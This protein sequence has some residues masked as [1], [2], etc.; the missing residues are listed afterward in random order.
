MLQVQSKL[1]VVKIRACNH[2]GIP[3]CIDTYM[4]AGIYIYI[5]IYIYICKLITTFLMRLNMFLFT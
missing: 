3:A 4:H 5:Y 2:T 1:G